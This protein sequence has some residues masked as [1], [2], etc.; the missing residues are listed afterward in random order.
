MSVSREQ[1]V[2]EAMTWLATPWR[3]QAML[4]GVG[5]DCIGLLAGIALETGIAD[6][7][8]HMRDPRFKG[9]GREPLPEVLLAACEEYLDSIEIDAAGLGDILLLKVPRG[10]NPQHFAVISRVA[11]G[12]PTHMLHATS[13][14][15]R[16]VVENS[17]D[18]AWWSRVLKAYR[19]KGVA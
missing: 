11:A 15:P 12:K 9:Y 8:A 14:Y 2:A 4:K 19:F 7:R 13:A 3:H 17:I 5:T 16:R 10:R 18:A 6:A 1:V